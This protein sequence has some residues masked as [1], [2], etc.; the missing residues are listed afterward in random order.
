MVVG[1]YLKFNYALRPSK[2]V[3]R[4]LLIEALLKLAAFD[5]NIPEYTYLGFGSVYYADF[6]VFNRYLYI[7]KMICVEGGDIPKRMEFNKPFGAIDLRLEMLS[8][9]IPTLDRSIQYLAWPDYDVP[10]ARTVL[11]DIRGLVSIL[12]PGSV[13]LVT[14]DADA[15]VRLEHPLDN[16]TGQEIR[17]ERVE[18]IN[19]DLGAFLDR[20]FKLAE[21]DNASLPAV[22]AGTMLN[23]INDEVAQRE[24]VSFCQLFNYRYRDGAQMLSLGGILDSPERVDRLSRSSFM[25]LPHLNQDR[26]PIEISVPPLT[27]LERQLL[28]RQVTSPGTDEPL[29]FELDDAF[30]DNFAKYRRYYPQYYESIT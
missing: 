8:D 24:D 15:R 9:V 30:R 14:V 6:Q 16:R 25:E 2:Q 5:Y 12:A 21:F 10:L 22:F 4:K 20:P 27:P 11:D 28:D 1:S 7:D 19:Q 26:E 23:V 18:M 29:P 3:E 13:L 17:A